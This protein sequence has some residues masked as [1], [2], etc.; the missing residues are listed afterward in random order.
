LRAVSAHRR[1]RRSERAQ[2][3]S[4]LL[5][6]KHWLLRLL[7]K[8]CRRAFAKSGRRRLRSE[9]VRGLDSGGSERRHAKANGRGARCI[10]WIC[11]GLLEVVESA[12]LERNA[13]KRG[14]GR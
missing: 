11:S 6:A 1:L 5:P 2:A 9:K 4:L 3:C 8:L 14:H 12:L 13:L 7:A 10:S